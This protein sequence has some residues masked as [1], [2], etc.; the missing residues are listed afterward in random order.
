MNK[1][2]QNS[3]ISV[4]NLYKNFTLYKNPR[5]DI[6]LENLFF[7]KRNSKKLCVLDNI[8]F[9]I[10]KGEVLGIIGMNGSGKS[11]L[12]RILVGSLL[13]T[14]G[15]FIIKGDIVSLLNISFATDGH[16]SGKETIHYI[17]SLYGLSKNYLD[18]II[19]E[20]V[21]FSEIHEF[22]DQPIRTYSTGMKARLLFS[23]IIHLKG[24]VF[25]IDEAFNGGDIYFIQKA[26]KKIKDLCNS[27]S[28]IVYISHNTSEIIEL[29]DK[30]LVLDSGKQKFLGGTYEGV[31][32][33]NNLIF[34]KQGEINKKI[35]ESQNLDNLKI[36]GNNSVSFNSI[37]LLDENNNLS[38]KFYYGEKIKINI[39]YESIF[40]NPKDLYLFIGIDTYKKN[41]FVGE[42]FL[43]QYKED[44]NIK[45]TKK[46]IISVE[47]PFNN[48]LNNNYSF[49]ISLR[50]KNT[51][52]CEYRGLAP[53]FS[54]RKKYSD[55]ID[56]IIG[57]PAKLL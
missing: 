48:L 10:Q 43:S 25:L 46:G 53:F 26:K 57:L 16:F 50:D 38:F 23:I 44:S 5:V 32:V 12:L 47:I 41:D 40:S 42:L 13:A 6:M 9:S 37:S 2:S 24:D 55:Q 35:S 45:I 7:I 17:M 34:S 14:K 4:S 36:S 21:D 1:F 27:G 28:T 15:E 33:Y 11:T 8:S 31:K 30:V 22:I 19:D 49:W 20:I 54:S 52:L 56:S 3:V 51:I 39:E 29:C 18:E